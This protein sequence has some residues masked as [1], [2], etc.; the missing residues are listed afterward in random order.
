MPF[1]GVVVAQEPS[2]NEPEPP[3]PAPVLAIL[4]GTV[5]PV[6]GPALPNGVVLIA[7]ERIVA[8]GT[9]EQVTIPADAEQLSFPAGHVYPGLVDALT[10][11]YTDALQ[12]TDAGLDAGTAIAD[13]M[14][15]RGDRDDDLTA[16]GI[17]TAFVGC[18]TPAVWR[19]IGAIVRPKRDG[20]E[21]AKDVSAKDLAR[22]AVQLRMT[23][24]PGPTHALQRQQ[25]L[26]AALKAF[27]GLEAYHKTFTDHQQ[28]LEKYGKDFEDYLAFHKKKSG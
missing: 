14:R 6:Q 12:R 26:D 27:D 24:G 5:H 16:A 4:A 10:D 20:F 3:P 18:R 21:F 23:T 7:G 2:K 8:V 11:A 22:A 17:T 15:L 25:A 13:G 1:A 19:G 9:R 28:A